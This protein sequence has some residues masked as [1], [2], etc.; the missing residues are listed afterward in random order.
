MKIRVN[1]NSFICE[2]NQ[3]DSYG[4][5]RPSTNTILCQSCRSQPPHKLISKENIIKKFPNLEVE[6]LDQMVEDDFIQEFT[7]I[8]LKI[9][10][11]VYLY[12]FHQIEKLS[13]RIQKAKHMYCES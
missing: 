11:K 1:L 8:N 9:Q 5:L 6:I 7:T 3:C 2:A 13:N 10:K 4:R 12:Y